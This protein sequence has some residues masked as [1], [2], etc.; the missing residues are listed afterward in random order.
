MKDEGFLDKTLPVD[1]KEGETAQNQPWML[2]SLPVNALN[3]CAFDMVF[4]EAL[5][6]GDGEKQEGPSSD[7]QSSPDSASQPESYTPHPPT[8]MAK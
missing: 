5:R 4:L 8:K 1:V 7:T 2:H 6:S 3:F